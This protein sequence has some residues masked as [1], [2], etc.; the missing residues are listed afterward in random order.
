MQVSGKW[1]ALV[2]VVVLGAAAQPTYADDA[3]TVALCLA[4]NWKDI[5]QCVPPVR[6]AMRDAAMGKPMKPCK[7]ASGPNSAE[8]GETEVTSIKATSSNCPV[9]ARRGKSCLYDGAVRV[10][11]DGQTWSNLWFDDKGNTATQDC[12]RAPAAPE[13]LT[14][15]PSLDSLWANTQWQTSFEQ[16]E[17]TAAA[18]APPS[19]PDGCTEADCGPIG[20]SRPP[21]AADAN[22]AAPPPPTLEDD[23]RGLAD[24]R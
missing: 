16:A 13:A 5:T 15:P 8:A 6:R 9:A 23:A 14:S 22:C 17:A 1:T 7:K 20:E 12:G 18:S 2:A 11:V 19:T 24:L 4:G 3:C 21:L 10:Q